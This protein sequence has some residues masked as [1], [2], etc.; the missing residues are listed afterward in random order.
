MPIF[1][2]DIVTRRAAVGGQFPE[3]GGRVSEAVAV[4]H[5][6]GGFPKLTEVDYAS[7]SVN[8]LKEYLAI[9][10]LATEPADDAYSFID[11]VPTDPLVSLLLFRPASLGARAGHTDRHA[12]ARNYME[13]YQI[14]AGLAPWVLFGDHATGL[15]SIQ[16]QALPG[17]RRPRVGQ[18][19][20]LSDSAGEQYVQI[21]GVS[22]ETQ[23]IVTLG[24]L[25]G[26]YELD[27]HT[28]TLYRP[29][30]R[31]FVGEG[32]SCASNLFPDT[33]VRECAVVTGRR[34]YG[35]SAVPA[36][37]AEGAL[38][39]QVDSIYAYAAPS[40]RSEQ[41][42][43]D[44][45]ALSAGAQTITSGGYTINVSGPA[46]TAREEITLANRRLTYTATLLPL[47][48]PT[49]KVRF[50]VR[51]EGEW[52]WVIEGEDNGGIGA[53]TSVDRSTG[54]AVLSLAFLPDPDSFLLC[55]W[56]S[57]VHYVDAAGT[58]DVVGFESA[59]NLPDPVEPGS[60][61]V[62]WPSGGA[63]KTMTFAAN[64]AGSGHGAWG[65]LDH[66]TGEYRI[67]HGSDI[68]DSDGALNWTYNEQSSVTESF[69][70]LTHEGG[71]V[72]PELAAV[73]VAGTLSLEWL[74]TEETKRTSAVRAGV[75]YAPA[76]REVRWSSFGPEE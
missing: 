76:H 24:E 46:H 9:Q 26:T 13:S 14:A 28:C 55:E 61:S 38:L 34:F 51:I 56:A 7:G 37:V 70:G 22:T 72:Y 25:C 59:G 1:P 2:S 31:A 48:A 60:A 21:V 20:H 16:L 6:L 58:A 44:V 69:T 63:T 33:E 12:D 75:R 50:R 54:T 71:F 53:I 3:S 52:Y 67:A 39:C 68:P 18:T 30:E 32:A 43:A 11:E 66:N 17:A 27:V 40:A 45:I 73:P 5:E 15:A 62:T 4:H 35:L 29:L 41:A 19:L 57:G 23:T 64:G 36:G 47:P 10:T 49:A 65:F 42:L 74:I 8:W